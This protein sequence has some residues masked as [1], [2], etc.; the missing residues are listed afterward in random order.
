[1]LLFDRENW[2]RHRPWAVLVAF[3]TL[4]ATLWYAVASVLASRLLGGGSLP[5]FTFGVVGGLI[6]LFEFLI[7]PR[8]KFR[9]WRIGRVQTWM[10]LH[11]WLGLLSLPILVLHSGFRWGGSLSA[12][13]MVLFLIVIASGV[14]GLLLQNILP[15][16]MLVDIPAETIHS[17]IDRIIGLYRDEAARLVQDTCGKAAASASPEVAEE[18]E[19]SDSTRHFVVGAVRSAG[20]IRG[21][22]LE[23]RSAG[24]TIAG[25]EPLRVFYESVASS[26]LQPEGFKGSPLRY[27]ERAEAIFNDL[28]TKL[29]PPAHP[30]ASTLENLCDQR[31]QL[32]EQQRLHF[33][34]HGW[35]VVH[36]PLSVALIVLMF[37]HI[38]EALKY[39]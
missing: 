33:W 23:S 20:K 31:R 19:A 15:K 17:Q 2:P 5:G 38:Y 11:I 29:D 18:E 37:V 1:M 27:A 34:M 21:K 24:P 35:L 26:F 8:K 9:A 32:A 16:K 10:T 14:W 13:L 36:L 25:S 30:A 3:A 28:R 7:W 22:V 39:L 4:G 6:C 12:G